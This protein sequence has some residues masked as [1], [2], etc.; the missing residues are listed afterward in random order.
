MYLRK[1]NFVNIFYILACCFY[2][3]YTKAIESKSENI[4]LVEKNMMI[5][6]E[7]KIPKSRLL[8]DKNLKIKRTEK[9][10]TIKINE[11]K[12]EI[13]QKKHLSANIKKKDNKENKLIKIIIKYLPDE[14][15]PDN[16]ELI[17]F[18]KAI[19]KFSNLNSITIQGYAEKREGDSTSKVRRLSLKRALF[20]R[21]LFLLLHLYLAKNTVE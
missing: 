21:K 16:N 20:L 19:T 14:E 7:I 5:A 1:F 3:H 4:D 15:K 9:N 11:K 2:A 8:T 17:T 13:K 6:E 12:R 10:Q 18:H